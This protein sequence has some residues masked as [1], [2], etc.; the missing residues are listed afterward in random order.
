MAGD[1]YNYGVCEDNYV[2]IFVDEC[3]E[4]I[5]DQLISMLARA[6]GSKF[7]LFVA[8]QTIQDFAARMGSEAK[9]YQVLGNVNNT[10]S[11]RI[12]EDKTQEYIAN[13]LPETR[14]KYVMTSQGTNTGSDSPQIFSG[15][16]SERLME[17]KNTNVHPPA[18]RPAS[19]F[20]ICCNANRREIS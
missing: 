18:F 10:I 5:C 8:T 11:L 19:R 4:V 2:N 3:S 13:K 20:R 14:V 17:E 12:T 16:Q 9:A 7:R 6:R 15:N 1:R